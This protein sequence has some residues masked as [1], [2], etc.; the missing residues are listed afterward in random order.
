MRCAGRGT[1]SELVRSWTAPHARSW[2]AGGDDAGRLPRGSNLYWYSYCLR[3]TGLDKPPLAKSAWPGH[4]PPPRVRGPDLPRRPARLRGFHSLGQ[5]DRLL[6][7]G[8][9]THRG[10]GL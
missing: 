10:G 5:Y 8:D 2:D 6:R 4:S 1:V 7:V 9:G 3:W